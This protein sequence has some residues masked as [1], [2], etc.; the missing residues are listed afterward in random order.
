LTEIVEP[1]PSSHQNRFHPP[2]PKQQ[3]DNDMNI[4]IL[5]YD[6]FT[7]LDA[8]GPYEVL[9]RLP[10]ANLTFVAAEPGPVLTDN[11]M[12]TL[13]AEH[14][15]EDISRPD[16]VLVPGGPGEVAARAGGPVLEWLRAAHLTSTWTTSVCTGS[17]ILAAA[18]LLDGRRATSHWLALGELRELGAE[19]ISERVV[20][21]G[22]IVTAAGV[23]AGIDMALTLAARVAG[24]EVAQAI[25]LGIEY[26]P[27]PPFD[28]GSP[29][30]APAAI[31]ELLRGRSR[32]MLEGQAESRRSSQ[33]AR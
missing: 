9:S 13:V 7:A 1:H 30:K 2:A 4:A 23:S 10:G 33:A 26:D 25:Q 32:F 20:F 18:G 15:I 6:R 24:E 3:G 19:P 16:I 17:L 11:G 21:D 29:H 28:A 31:V 27:Q 12:L 5:L 8:I 14:S 22:K